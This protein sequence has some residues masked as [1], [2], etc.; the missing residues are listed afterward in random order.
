MDLHLC[1]LN[2]AVLRNPVHQQ[3]SS[4]FVRSVEWTTLLL[5]LMLCEH[6]YKE[7]CPAPHA[8]ADQV[9]LLEARV[10]LF[11]C[12]VVNAGHRDQIGPSLTLC[13]GSDN[14]RLLLDKNSLHILVQLL[15]T[16]ANARMNSSR[17]SWGNDSGILM[18]TSQ[19]LGM[20]L[21]T[22]TSLAITYDLYHASST[23][24]LSKFTAAPNGQAWLH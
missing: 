22:Q 19:P 4:L 7:V 20:N 10:R 5:L 23:C 17:L 3:R 21:H 2:Y 24:R 13:G 15:L 14:F 11:I 16:L 12:P 6:G 8:I 9:K 1:L 18:S